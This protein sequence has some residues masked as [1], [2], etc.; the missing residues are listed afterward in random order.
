MLAHK[1]SEQENEWEN[2]YKSS[3]RAVFVRVREV[4]KCE[5]PIS[6]MRTNNNN[7]TVNVVFAGN[8]YI[9]LLGNDGVDV[10]VL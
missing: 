8:F 3:V 6:G 7:V 10:W 2:P 1:K 4:E 5:K 9:F